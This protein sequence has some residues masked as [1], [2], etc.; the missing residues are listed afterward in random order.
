MSPGSQKLARRGPRLA[1]P[2]HG[3]DPTWVN[4]SPP[5]LALKTDEAIR[6]NLHAGQLL[7]LGCGEPDLADL[8]DNH[9]DRPGLT[10]EGLEQFTDRLAGHERITSRSR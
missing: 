3:H 8:A 9:R 5:G 1:V 4:L 10:D 6:A 2:H 7:V